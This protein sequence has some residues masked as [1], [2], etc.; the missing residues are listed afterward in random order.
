MLNSVLILLLYRFS[1]VHSLQLLITHTHLSVET[2][3][4][5]VLLDSLTHF[6]DEN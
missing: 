1:S 4:G 3:A 2:H 5:H 6:I